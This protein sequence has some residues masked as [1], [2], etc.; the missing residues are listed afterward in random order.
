[1]PLQ[2]KKVNSDTDV[3]IE[4]GNVVIQQYSTVSK[5]HKVL[6]LPKDDAIDLADSIY[7]LTGKIATREA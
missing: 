5:E 6:V 4:S 2:T 3:A 7:E 1:M